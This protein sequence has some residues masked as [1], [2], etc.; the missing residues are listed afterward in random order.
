MKKPLCI[1]HA[2]CLD[3][4]GAAWVVHKA[5]GGEIDFHPGVYQEKLPDVDDRKVILVDFSY[6]NDVMYELVSRSKNVIIID[7]HKSAIESLSTFMAPK[8]VAFQMFL[9]TSHSGAMLAWKYF[10]PEEQPP[11]LIRHIE[12]RD[13]WLFHLPKTREINA[14]LVSYPFDFS[15]WDGLMELT[16]HEPMFLAK[17]GEALERMHLKNVHATIASGRRTMKIG[18]C[19]VP[20]VNA[21]HGMASDI[22]NIMSAESSLFAATYVDN[23]DHRSF[24]LRSARDGMDV[25]KIAQQYGGG[26]HRNAA[27]FKM[28]IGWEGD[29]A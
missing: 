22:G 28:P 27:G 5:F 13:L 10:F 20:V 9:D 1:Y 15:V 7:H 24:S 23:S 18:G 11:H 4:F 14:A 19:Y 3:G 25:S 21:P 12:D 6:K 17:E 16:Q 8:G 29:N 2:N 26:G